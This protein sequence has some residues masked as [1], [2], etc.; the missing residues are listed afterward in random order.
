VTT[1]VAAGSAEDVLAA[2][3]RLAVIVDRRLGCSAR[4]AAALLLRQE[5]ER[6]LDE[7]WQRVAPGLERCSMRAQLAALPFYLEPPELAGRVALAWQQL[8][9]LCHHDAYELAPLPSE[10]LALAGVVHQLGSHR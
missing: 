9:A 6:L 4:T 5:L 8:S 1:P 3:R 2:A 7:H 10:L